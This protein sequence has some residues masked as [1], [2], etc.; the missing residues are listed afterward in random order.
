MGARESEERKQARGSRRKVRGAEINLLLLSLPH[1]TLSMA[2]G[3][4]NG[5]VAAL[6]CIIGVVGNSVLE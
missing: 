1:L 2:G 4:V 6:S 5:A 3:K